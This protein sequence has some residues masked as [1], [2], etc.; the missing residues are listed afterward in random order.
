MLK[1][2]S[3]LKLLGRLQYPGSALLLITSV[4]ILIYHSY[5]LATTGLTTQIFL[6]DHSIPARIVARQISIALLV[7]SSLGLIIVSAWY[8]LGQN[9]NRQFVGLG[10]PLVSLA[11]LIT[12]ILAVITAGKTNF[13][14]DVIDSRNYNTSSQISSYV[15][16]YP[17]GLQLG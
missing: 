1:K 12:T 7:F 6:D 10:I 17:G 8:L 4:G 2:S 13:T 16:K 15:D 11:I 14:L 9:A 3:P 5:Y